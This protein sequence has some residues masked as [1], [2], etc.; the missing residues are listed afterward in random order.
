VAQST[1]TNLPGSTVILWAIIASVIVLFNWPL[2]IYGW[3]LYGRFYVE[4]FVS[5]ISSLKNDYCIALT[6]DQLGI[7]R[8]FFQYTKPIYDFPLLFL[9]AGVFLKV[10]EIILVYNILRRLDFVPDAA[11]MFAVFLPFSGG[12]M[13]S[14][15][16]GLITYVNFN[17]TFISSLLSLAGVYC[18]L[19]NRP[20]WAG[21]LLGLACYF[22]IP[23]GITAF[24]FIVAGTVWH[25]VAKKNWR[26][27]PCLLSAGGLTLLPLVWQTIQLGR[28]VDQPIGLATWYES[29]MQIM[30]GVWGNDFLMTASVL[31]NGLDFAI[32][33]ATYLLLRTHDSITKRLD[34][35]VFAGLVLIGASLT[36]E[37]LHANGVFI[38]KA[39]EIFITI[40]MRRGIWVPFVASYIGLVRILWEMRDTREITWK[41]A[42]TF[43]SILFWLRPYH[44]LAIIIAVQLVMSFRHQQRSWYYFIIPIGFLGLGSLYWYSYPTAYAGTWQTIILQT[45]VMLPIVVFAAC[46]PRIAAIRGVYRIAL[47]IVLLLSILTVRQAPKW[48]THLRLLSLHGWLSP[49]NSE[50]LQRLSSG[51]SDLFEDEAAPPFK[52][53]KLLQQVNVDL[54]PVLVDP[55]LGGLLEGRLPNLISPWVCA[56]LTLYSY[57]AASQIS[58]HFEET[59]GRHFS[60]NELVGDGGRAT[61]QL[62]KVQD[63]QR[64]FDNNSI[65]AFISTKQYPELSMASEVAPYFI[66]IK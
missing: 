23:Y 8:Y 63:V 18:I 4:T 3:R 15:A 24:I 17:K 62:L 57:A 2:D 26:P 22:H 46:T 41:W 55:A 64:L 16:N 44:A 43:W 20:G 49:I 5:N 12:I 31:I 25:D 28:S 66:Y 61:F 59:F 37:A 51:E 21:L 60:L 56:N 36:L 6:Y 65:G 48:Y 35:Y 34:G 14:A 7:I 45:A 50:G 33:V 40:Q 39:S 27:A 19:A 13:G 9:F 30:G 11:L 54:K 53:L 47:P 10:V 58:Q 42:I 52:V 38:P 29:M 32:P 1:K